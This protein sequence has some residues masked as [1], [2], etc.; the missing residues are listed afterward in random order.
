MWR[1]AVEAEEKAVA[2][3]E[4]ATKS[5]QLES[6]ARAEAEKS[7]D[8]TKLAVEEARAAQVRAEQAFARSQFNA[9]KA[10][11]NSRQFNQC[12]ESLS[13]VPEKDRQVE[14]YLARERFLGAEHVMEAFEPRLDIVDVFDG[15]GV[16][17][18]FDFRIVAYTADGS[19]IVASDP[20]TVHFFEAR[21]GKLRRT[22][23]REELEPGD[24]EL[25]DFEKEVLNDIL[26]ENTSDDLLSD[27]LDVESLIADGPLML[28]EEIVVANDFVGPSRLSNIFDGQQVLNGSGILTS[29]LL[30]LERG[31]AT[32]FVA[33]YSDIDSYG[34]IDDDLIE[35]GFDV[36]SES[37]EFA[38][39]FVGTTGISL[40][41]S[42]S[43]Q[44]VHIIDGQSSK[45]IQSLHFDEDFSVLQADFT[46]DGTTV[47][48]LGTTISDED[49]E[50]RPASV[51]ELEL[52]AA[53]GI[54][55]QAKS[56]WMQTKLSVW[57]LESN[58]ILQTFVAPAKSHFLTGA[59]FDPSGSQIAVTDT[60]GAIRLH[61]WK[62]G[63]LI[64]TLLGHTGPSF[65]CFAPDGSQ[66]ASIGMDGTVRS[67][68]LRTIDHA[69]K[70]G[71]INCLSFTFGPE[72]RNLALGCM[73]GTIRCWNVA[74]RKFYKQLT[75]SDRPI[76]SVDWSPDGKLIASLSSRQR[77]IVSLFETGHIRNWDSQEFVV[78]RESSIDPTAPAYEVG[79]SRRG[80]FF[81][82]IL[83][84]SAVS[85]MVTANRVVF[86]PDGTLF[87][88]TTDTVPRLLDPMTGK[89]V[90]VLEDFGHEI[91]EFAFAPDGGS[92]A[93]ISSEGK[94]CIW[95]VATGNQLVV[96]ERPQFKPSNRFDRTSI[97]S[98]AYS[99]SGEIA[100]P[101]KTHGVEFYDPELEKQLATFEGHSDIVTTIAF[102]ADGSRMVTGS[103]DNTIKI[104]DTSSQEELFSLPGHATHVRKVAIS[105][106]GYCI[107]SLGDDGMVKIW[108]ARS[109]AVAKYSD[110]A[111]RG[112]QIT[113]GQTVDLVSAPGWR[114]KQVDRASKAGDAY[115]GAFHLGWLCRE[116]GATPAIR[117]RLRAAIALLSDAQRVHLPPFIAAFADED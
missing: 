77:P 107:A 65:T 111:I 68:N 49:E 89:E 58:E 75:P 91:Q 17:G 101:S 114:L 115:A 27:K 24:D 76:V 15:I 83:G 43:H 98:F 106:D 112:N 50:S 113:G 94:I 69:L 32:S 55:Q 81:A 88:D 39:S 61:D 9:A 19:Q 97:H 90:V 105:P 26:P 96:V 116:Q 16:W 93:A 102:S 95:D 45:L 62:S 33:S 20:D 18:A 14:W 59:A 60:T 28:R 82:S 22:I 35:L 54:N 78:G 57:D 108:D 21:S 44:R 4:A 63:K 41:T 117:K 73:D 8:Q 70:L 2:R 86:S 64:R 100:F 3:A 29:G 46:T 67:W 110:G 72:G 103:L 31:K 85:V 10:Q 42:G 12:I 74:D 5:K 23:S 13:Q 25:S 36:S 47:A 53:L 79:Y 87:A 37:Q 80:G 52:N 71:G 34:D 6:K 48:L 99:P 66:I 92:C 56:R 38:G 109:R 7:R 30:L 11:F 104:W 84:P 40:V 1:R 51:E